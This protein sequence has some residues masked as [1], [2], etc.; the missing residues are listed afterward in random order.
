MIE[1]MVQN[2]VTRWFALYLQNEK[3]RAFFQY[4]LSALIYTLASTLGLLLIGAA[5]HAFTSAVI[6]IAVLY[7]NQ[8]IGGG[9]HARSHLA[10]SSVM[11]VALIGVVLLCK[12]DLPA[13]FLLSISLCSLVGMFFMPVVLHSRRDYLSGR[14]R[15]FTQKVKL[16]IMFETSIFLI[17]FFMNM[18][19]AAIAWSLVVS[20]ISR[21][22][23]LMMKD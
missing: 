12:I 13:F 15:E 8:T 11:S 3:K 4:G 21:L 17:V 16:C 7:F 20:C 19:R 2:A 22:A 6:F 10:C 23:A 1:R 14:L 5:F 18:M 9:F